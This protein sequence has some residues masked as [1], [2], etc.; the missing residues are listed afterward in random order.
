M[1]YIK[2]YEKK[3]KQPEYYDIYD[4][5]R[6]IKDVDY[7]LNLLETKN[8]SDYDKSRLFY[9]S[10]RELP[11][12]ALK[13]LKILPLQ[14]IVENKRGIVQLEYPYFS[15]ILKYKDLYKYLITKN[16][17]INDVLFY[18]YDDDT[19]KLI[20]LKKLGYI[21]TQNNLESLSYTNKINNIKYLVNQGFD[22]SLKRK[23]SYGDMP[24]NCLDTATSYGKENIEVIKYLVQNLHIPVTYRHIY[25]VIAK[26][27][28]EAVPILVNTKKFSDD[29]SYSNYATNDDNRH[30]FRL[31]S[32][33]YPMLNNNL[34][35]YLKILLKNRNV[36]YSILQSLPSLT[37][38]NKNYTV[39]IKY[40]DPKY[41]DFAYEI[42]NNYDGK[43]EN[44]ETTTF[45]TH[46]NEKYWLKKMK[47]NPSIISKLT[48]LEEDFKTS[49]KYQKI[50]LDADAKN[51]KYIIDDLNPRI[52]EEYSDIPEILDKT[53]NKYNL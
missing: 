49:Y 16:D 4:D 53:A 26:R 34:D 13:L 23:S 10:C 32:L 29:Y 27:N 22:P 42:L 38:H 18:S 2:T 11:E 35:E 5:L 36:G 31:N 37:D 15:K 19:R 46:N 43:Y 8:I 47:Q 9:W 6:N 24:Q 14:M 41:L 30:Q 28:L 25:N 7:Y 52:M 1:K 40:L 48:E 20:L 17:F 44:S 33:I 50:I 51:V 45:I 21:F 12:L 3:I 39:K